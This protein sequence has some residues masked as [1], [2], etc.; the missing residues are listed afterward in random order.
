[1]IQF[2]HDFLTQL[3]E[4]VKHIGPLEVIDVAV[5]TFVLYQLLR[6]GHVRD[7]ESEPAEVVATK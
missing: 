1:M 4:V 6:P 3:N 2:F 5:V 7:A